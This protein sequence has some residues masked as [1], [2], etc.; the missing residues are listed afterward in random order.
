MVERY[1]DAPNQR[2]LFI[3]R[4]G[5]ERGWIL[6]SIHSIRVDALIICF[7]AGDESGR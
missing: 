5:H 4:A 6:R 2:A 7:M 3:G 1:T